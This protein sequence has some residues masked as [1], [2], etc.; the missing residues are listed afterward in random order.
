MLRMRRENLAPF[1]TNQ[2]RKFC[3]QVITDLIQAGLL[4]PPTAPNLLATEQS[5]QQ[6]KTLGLGSRAGQFRFLTAVLILRTSF[7]EDPRVRDRLRRPGQDEP[8]RCAFLERYLRL[9]LANGRT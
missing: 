2:R 1:Q 7:T 8:D 5:F 9:R 3:K 4:E 6:A